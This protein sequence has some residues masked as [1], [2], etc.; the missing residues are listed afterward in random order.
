M[1]LRSIVRLTLT[2]LCLT[3]PGLAQNLILGAEGGLRFTGDV[4]A[5]GFSNSKPYLMGPK[6][7]VGLPLHFALEADIL[8]S[9]LGNTLY[10]PLV[11]NESTIRTIAN[12]WAFPVLAKYRL[13]VG[14]THPFLS[15]GFVP[16][17]AGGRIHTIHYGYYPSDVT[18]SSV[19][20]QAHDHA[21]VLG[22]GIEVGLWKI[23]I[24]PELRYLRWKVPSSPSPDDA[25]YY[26]AVPENE[27]QFLLGIGWSVK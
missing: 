14:R 12:S 25:S 2:W 15:L 3:I 22:G 6:I 21:W 18:F 20:W 17:Y 16:R 24:T 23:R 4:P 10:I 19:G 13:P 8:Y 9:R 7:E 11:A 26:L 1:G 27:G 5:Y